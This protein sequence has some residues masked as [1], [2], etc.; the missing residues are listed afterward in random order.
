MVFVLIYRS[1]PRFLTRAK[2]PSQVTE[3]YIGGHAYHTYRLESPDRTVRR[4]NT[5]A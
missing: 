3:A 1:S 5:R 2:P 4:A